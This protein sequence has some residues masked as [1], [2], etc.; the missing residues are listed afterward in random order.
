MAVFN[1]T[2][3]IEIMTIDGI[4]I[5]QS[6]FDELKEQIRKSGKEITTSVFIVGN[7]SATE[8]FVKIKKRKAE[9]VGIKLNEVRFDENVSEQELLDAIKEEGD[10]GRTI[11]VQLPLPN[12]ID[13]NRILNSIPPNLDVDVLSKKSNQLY[14]EGKL[15]ILPPVMGAIKEILDRESINVEGKKIVIIGKGALV[16]KPVSLWFKSKKNTEVVM[17]DKSTTDLKPYTID[18]DIVVTGVGI[19]NLITRDMVK[20]EVILLDAGTSEESGQLKGDISKDCEDKASI[21][22]P[23]PGGIGPITVAVLLR[24]IVKETEG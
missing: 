8:S 24:N 21:F 3:I 5:A 19:P 4:E 18:A 20:D 22:T 14:E 9:E 7:N 11:V 12:S 13:K 23:V 6:I 10:L 16:G 2:G 15:P 1:S 17:L